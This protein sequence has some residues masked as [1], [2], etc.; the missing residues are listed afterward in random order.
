MNGT[1]SYVGLTWDHP[2]G[3][4]ALERAAEQA[5]AQGLALRWERQPLEG[6]ESHPIEE[7]AA[8]YDIIV[9]DH[10]HLGDAVLSDCFQPLE[11]I[12]QASEIEQ[13]R[14]QSIGRALDS[15]RYSGQHWALPLD[16]AAQVAVVRRDLLDEPHPKSWSEV[17]EFA[18]RQSVCLSLAGPHAL[19]TLYSISAAFGAPPVAQG[20][21]RLLEVEGATS[22]W[23]LFSELYSKSYKGWIGKNPIGILQAMARERGAAYCPLIFGYVNYAAT[24]DGSQLLQFVDVPAG[25]DGHLGSTLGG[26]G[27]GVSRRAQVSDQLRAHLVDLL[28]MR[29]QT[30]FIPFADGQPSARNAWSDAAV[31]KTWNDFFAGTC[32]TLEQA[33]VRP[34]HP[35]Y[36][37]F[38]TDASAM[39]RDALEQRQSA[40]QILGALQSLYEQ[41]RPAN[42]EA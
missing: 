36:I 6:F 7:L 35:G 32:A 15:Y 19:L 9:L 42:S 21:E 37:P 1:T 4:V 23:A 18:T 11:S 29:T 2:R 10:P 26:T 8:R 16:A 24:T 38:Q 5:R 22:A 40:A 25:P 20:P 31:N 12:F 39:V 27:I 41:R 30:Q 3:Y 28:S 13:W 33:I 17:V 14:T 34:R